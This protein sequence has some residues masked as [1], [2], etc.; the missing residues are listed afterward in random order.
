MK[1]SEQLLK[2]NYLFM[3]VLGLHCCTGFSLVEA[4]RS[5]PLV[6]VCWLLIVVASLVAEHGL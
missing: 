6:V 5:Y 4:S 2:K 3:A 1:S